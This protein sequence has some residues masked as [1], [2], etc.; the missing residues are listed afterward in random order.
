MHVLRRSQGFPS[1]C[2]IAFSVKVLK[3]SVQ[4]SRAFFLLSC[5]VLFWFFLVPPRVLWKVRRKEKK[6]KELNSPCL[7]LPDYPAISPLKQHKTES[8]K[9]G[10]L[11]SVSFSKTLTPHNTLSVFPLLCGKKA[12]ENR[13]TLNSPPHQQTPLSI[14]FAFTPPPLSPR[15]TAALHHTS[16]SGFDSF[17][18]FSEK[19]PQRKTDKTKNRNGGWQR[20]PVRL[21]YSASLREISARVR[22][23]T[24]TKTK[25]RKNG[26]LILILIIV[27]SITLHYI[28]Y[29]NVYY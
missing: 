28:M 23:E 27:I 10:K 2:P 17:F 12:A 4:I 25:T 26:I 16:N 22:D 24:K 21:P 7:L 8:K 18:L 14:P 19:T 5:S 11:T 6:R 15:I 9:E 1:L 29:Y 20:Y 3:F 13:E